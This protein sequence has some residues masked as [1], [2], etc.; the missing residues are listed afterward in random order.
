[1]IKLKD[2]I[3]EGKLKS[4]K[5]ITN[6][7]LERMAMAA[8]REYDSW[9]QNEEGMDEE[10]GTGGICHLIA[11][12]LADILL[13]NGIDA[14]TV[15]SNYE[16]HVYVVARFYEGVYI[17]DIPYSV[18]ETGGG[19]TWKKLPNVKFDTHHVTI[20]RIDS[21]PKK[22]DQYTDL[23][24]NINEMEGYD[25]LLEKMGI[26]KRF[27]IGLKVAFPQ[28][29]DIN[30]SLKSDGEELHLN[31]IRMKPGETGK[32]YGKKI[33]DKIIQFA[34]MNGYYI[35]LKPVPDK[36]YKEKLHRFYKMFGFYPNKGRKGI[37]RYGGAFGI[38][39]IRPP[40][41]KQIDK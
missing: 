7:I 13:E 25:P 17:I 23:Y 32:G 14:A 5:I 27:E 18:Y 24:E 34:D 10:M 12:K 26:V 36:G 8:Q 4:V 19:F 28:L 41:P 15:S 16:Q 11:E 35:T 29:A 40:K 31:S 38:Y 6:N 33:M 30:L 1:M 20:G 2:L 3:L 39:W 21:N 9:Y 22:F 37:D